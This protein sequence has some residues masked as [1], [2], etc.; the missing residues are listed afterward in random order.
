MKVGSGDQQ[1]AAHST[2]KDMFLVFF[3]DLKKY[4]S[5]Y[6]MLKRQKVYINGG[7]CIREYGSHP[8]D[9]GLHKGVGE[10]SVGPPL[11]MSTEHHFPLAGKELSDE[12]GMHGRIEYVPD[13]RLFL[14][15]DDTV[16]K[17]CINN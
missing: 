13:L 7:V 8:L 1:I 2:E 17:S 11:I 16:S 6:I 15:V 12:L 10:W 9:S 3:N 5:C 14:Q 4:I